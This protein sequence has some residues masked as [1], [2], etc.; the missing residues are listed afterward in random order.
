MTE[1]NRENRYVVFKN[2]DVCKYLTTQE[3]GVLDSLWHKVEFG[4]C[5]DG[6]S[7]L[8]YVVV[9]DNWPMY[10]MV[11]DMIENWAEEKNEPRFKF[12][13]SSD[14]NPW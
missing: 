2:E 10:E 3:L 7:D 8:K 11:W 9:E 12:W 1:F 4:R 13:D 14:G 5:G 6:K